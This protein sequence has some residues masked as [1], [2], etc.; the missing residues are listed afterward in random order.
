MSLKS[1]MLK[2]ELKIIGDKIKH[3][4][5]DKKNITLNYYILK[6]NLKLDK[7]EEDIIKY[8][9]E[10]LR[11]LLK[12]ESKKFNIIEEEY[13]KELKYLGVL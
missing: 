9:I 7:E 12:I 3:I 10:V 6:N 8:D 2:R 4:K 5:S 13:Y 1:D 11:V